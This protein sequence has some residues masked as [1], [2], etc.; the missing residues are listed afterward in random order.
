MA[1]VIEYKYEGTFLDL[2][3]M[4]KVLQSALANK[5]IAE[6]DYTK[7]ADP[8]KDFV[9]FNGRP[10]KALRAVRNEILSLMRNPIPKYPYT[11]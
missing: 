9:W 6:F 11:P 7:S 5:V 4:E 10:G 2:D 8:T 1:R 3:K